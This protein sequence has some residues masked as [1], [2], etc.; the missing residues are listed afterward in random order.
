M[1]IDRMKKNLPNEKAS[2]ITKTIVE[3]R[4]KAMK[5]SAAEESKASGGSDEE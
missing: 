3:K 4:I 1:I 2:Q 5:Q